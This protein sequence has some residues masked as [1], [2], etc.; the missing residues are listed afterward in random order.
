MY[1][2][3]EVGDEFR[4]GDKNEKGYHARSNIHQRKPRMKKE[5]EDNR[6]LPHGRD[7]YP[8]KLFSIQHNPRAQP[9]VVSP[10]MLRQL[11]IRSNVNGW[12]ATNVVKSIRTVAQR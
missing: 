6:Q 7:A 2:Y 10:R 12:P 11:R 1:S 5:S 4:A 8:R 3:S 9:T